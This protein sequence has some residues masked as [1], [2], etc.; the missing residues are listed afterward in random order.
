MIVLI[1][2][3][4]ALW[5]M[6]QVIPWMQLRSRKLSLSNLE[7]FSPLIK[8]SIIAYPHNKEVFDVLEIIRDNKLEISFT[9]VERMHNANVNFQNVVK[10]F[11]LVKTKDI[12]ISSEDLKEWAYSSNDLVA[13][14]SA[15]KLGEEIRFADML[16]RA[17][18][19][20]M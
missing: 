7:Y 6:G 20:V 18:R 15:R 2:F 3:V 12:R 11:L 14:I 5:L 4:F 8:K 17:K 13:E 1:F 16:G 19:G 10:A 9:D